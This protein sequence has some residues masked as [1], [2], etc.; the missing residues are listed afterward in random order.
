MS[1]DLIVLAYVFNSGIC[2][3]I[4]YNNYQSIF[5]YR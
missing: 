1:L 3:G 5:V 2:I 4:I